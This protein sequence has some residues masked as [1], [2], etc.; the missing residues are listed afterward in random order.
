MRFLNLVEQLQ[1]AVV[2]NV[3]PRADDDSNDF[4]HF[5]GLFVDVL[6]FLNRLVCVRKRLEISKILVRP[7][8]TPSMELNAFLNLLTD[9][10]LW[11][12]IR[13][14]ESLV[15]AKSAS[16]RADSPIPIGATE[17]RIDADF[18]HSPT[19][20]LLEVVAVAVETTAVK[21]VYVGWDWGHFCN[22]S[23]VWFWA[24]KVCFFWI[25]RQQSMLLRAQSYSSNS[26]MQISIRSFK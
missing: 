24:V 14:I 2:D 15:A 17:T 19:E 1:D 8:I 18:L 5:Q 16:S 20:L 21:M 7:A 9:G 3:R 23:I 22:R 11:P 6:Q 26:L 10:L 25:Y 4:G 13:R 12:T